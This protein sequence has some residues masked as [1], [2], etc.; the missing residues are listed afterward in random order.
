MLFFLQNVSSYVKP[1]R[2]IYVYP[3]NRCPVKTVFWPK[4]VF[5]F[6][7]PD[8]LFRGKIRSN[9]RIFIYLLARKKGWYHRMFW[10]EKKAWTVPSLRGRAV[11]SFQ[12]K[13]VPWGFQ[14]PRKKYNF[15]IRAWIES[16]PARI[17]C[18]EKKKGCWTTDIWTEIWLTKTNWRWKW[19]CGN[20]FFLWRGNGMPAENSWS[21]QT[22]TPFKLVWI[23]LFS[24]WLGRKGSNLELNIKRGG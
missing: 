17:G 8:V 6:P 15:A 2:R 21:K 5:R 16:V 12:G 4:N 24:Q 14:L 13:R 10:S 11:A 23:T 20:S 9:F 7:F 1:D 3:V 19:F 22:F 18:R